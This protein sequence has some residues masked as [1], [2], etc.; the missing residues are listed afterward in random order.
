MRRV[1]ETNPKLTKVSNF[2]MGY[3]Y[4]LFNIVCILSLLI[5]VDLQILFIPGCTRFSIEGI[6]NNLKAFNSST[7]TAG[8][9]H[10]KT[11]GFYGITLD[12]YEQ[13][14]NLFG[15]Q[16]NKHI[17][18]YYHRVNLHAPC[19]DDRALDV[20]ICLRCQNLRLVY[21]RPAGGCRP[22]DQCQAC[23]ICIPR[24]RGVHGS[25]GSVFTINH[26]HNR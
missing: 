17:P 13:L 7:E 5:N 1:L 15:V 18:H 26:N 12:H 4:M 19:D 10:T 6:L 20:E 11:G 2:Y 9:K 25:V 24:C 21:D 3:W 16:N 8:I 14:N 23:I 22:K